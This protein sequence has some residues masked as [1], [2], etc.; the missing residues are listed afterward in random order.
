VS[1]QIE[2]ISAVFRRRVR[3]AGAGTSG[4]GRTSRVERSL[5]GRSAGRRN[6]QPDGSYRCV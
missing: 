1:A 2:E 4:S 6:R 3:G 5:G